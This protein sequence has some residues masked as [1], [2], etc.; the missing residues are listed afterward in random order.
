M[1]GEERHAVFTGPLQLL[2]PEQSV[3]EEEL[4][5]EEAERQVKM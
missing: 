1:R 4:G 5:Q 3:Q 2:S